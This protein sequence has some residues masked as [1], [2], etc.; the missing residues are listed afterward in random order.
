M[1]PPFRC[2]KSA[3]LSGFLCFPNNISSHK[4][5]KFF[6]SPVSCV[7]GQKRFIVQRFLSPSTG[8]FP[9][10]RCV[11]DSVSVIG[12][13]NAKL[14]FINSTVETTTTSL[15]KRYLKARRETEKIP[16]AKIQIICLR[17]AGE[18]GPNQ[19]V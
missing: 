9:R 19:L 15:N 12:S 16:A 2:L 17:K 13:W 8:S 10:P 18:D 14:N 6:S 3:S 7:V 5:T 1:Q 11:D 4:T